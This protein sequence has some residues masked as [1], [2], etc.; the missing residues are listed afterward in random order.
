MSGW[1]GLVE[2]EVRTKLLLLLYYII[3]NY[4][5]IS[6]SLKEGWGNMV[7]PDVEYAIHGT[8]RQKGE[9]YMEQ[10]DRKDIRTCKSQEKQKGEHETG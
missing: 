5:I 6:Y 10:P 8:T 9:K 2:K 4:Y 3:L 1:N 7:Q